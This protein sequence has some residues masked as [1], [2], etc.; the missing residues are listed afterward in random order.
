MPPR[1]LMHCTLF[2]RCTSLASCTL[3]STSFSLVSGSLVGVNFELNLFSVRSRTSISAPSSVS[4]ARQGEKGGTDEKTEKE[5]RRGL[6]RLQL[7]PLRALTPS[8]IRTGSL[9][10]CDW[11]SQPRPPAPGPGRA[12]G[13]GVK[14]C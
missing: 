12:M 8:S 14:V 6:L 9:T 1:A 11:W 13:S 3:F 2:Q 10:R 7:Q 4:A 5:R